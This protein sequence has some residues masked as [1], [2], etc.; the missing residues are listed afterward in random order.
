MPSQQDAARIALALPDVTRAD[1]EFSFRVNGRLF[2]HAWRERTDPKKPKVPNREV[3]VVGVRDE[4]DKQTLLS[5]G[6]PALFT[7]PHYDGYAAVL[8]RLPDVDDTF[9]QKLITDSYDLA[10]SKPPPRPRRPKAPRP[11]HF[12]PA[13]SSFCGA[14]DR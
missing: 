14:V 5:T 2:L 8:V 10:A 3:V 9:L 6:N 7:E 1:D 4:M 12:S 11:P 13:R